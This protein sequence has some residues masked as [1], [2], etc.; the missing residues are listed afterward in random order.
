MI[1]SRQAGMGLSIP[2]YSKE[3]VIRKAIFSHEKERSILEEIRLF[4]VTL[5]RAKA[6][7]LLTGKRL[8]R[9][10][11]SRL[12]LLL[13]YLEDSG[14]ESQ[15]NFDYAKSSPGETVSLQKSHLKIVIRQW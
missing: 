2:G 5:T 6:H 11:T 14:G 3:N 4:Y 10:N 1:L 9:K 12:S 15:F 13:P 8:K 7:I